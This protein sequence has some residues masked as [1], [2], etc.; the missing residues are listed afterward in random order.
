MF[1]PDHFVMQCAILQINEISVVQGPQQNGMG[2]SNGKYGGLL[3]FGGYPPP[4]SGGS[5]DRQESRPPSREPE[6][7]WDLHFERKAASETREDLLPPSR[8]GLAA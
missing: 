5:P 8:E 3:G 7:L 2:A 1:C 6:R 4:P